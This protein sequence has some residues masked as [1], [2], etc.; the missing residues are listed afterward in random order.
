MLVYISGDKI[1]DARNNQTLQSGYFIFKE[2]VRYCNRQGWKW[3]YV[4]G[5]RLLSGRKLWVELGHILSPRM[6][7]AYLFDRELHAQIYDVVVKESSS[8]VPRPYI[9]TKKVM[10]SLHRRGDAEFF[11]IWFVYHPTGVY[12]STGDAKAVAI[13]QP[14]PPQELK[15]TAMQGGI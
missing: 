15:T 14:A 2:A 11:G 13:W 9:I 12:Y 10:R 5:E 1:I 4:D 7:D 6:P 8:Y 3:F